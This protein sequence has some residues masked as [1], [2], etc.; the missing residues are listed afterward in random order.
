MVYVAAGPREAF[1]INDTGTVWRI[2]QSSIDELVSPECFYDVAGCEDFAIAVNIR[3]ECYG[4][5]RIVARTE[6]T[7][8]PDLVGR[9]VLHV[10]A[11]SRR[12]FVL[13]A[14]G[15]VLV[16]GSGQNGELGTETNEPYPV[17]R[18]LEL[19]N[20]VDIGLGESHT[21][22]VT[23]D[24]S[25]FG[26]GLGLDGRLFGKKGSDVFV[27][28][29]ESI[30]K[31]VNVRCGRMSTF[32]VV[33]RP[34]LRHLGILHFLNLSRCV[35]PSVFALRDDMIVRLMNLDLM[36]GDLVSF[37]GNEAIVVG[38]DHK[39]VRIQTITG[40]IV[41][42]ERS[43]LKFIDRKGSEMC[44]HKGVCYDG[45]DV[46]ERWFGLRVGDVVMKEG[47]CFE[48]LGFHKGK[49]WL[50]NCVDEEVIAYNGS[51]SDFWK[52]YSLE[53]T[54][55]NVVSR[56]IGG[57]VY[58]IKPME[59]VAVVGFGSAH[60]VQIIGEFAAF[61]IGHPLFKPNH[62][63]L[64]PKQQCLIV[65]RCGRFSQYDRVE[66]EGQA[67]MLLEVCNDCGLVILDDG[68]RIAA[69]PVL[70]PLESLIVTTPFRLIPM[71]ASER[72]IPSDVF[73]GER[74]FVTVVGSKV[75]GGVV[76]MSARDCNGE[77][78]DLELDSYALVRRFYRI[79]C[80]PLRLSVNPLLELSV[81]VGDMVGFGFLPFDE[82]EID[83]SSWIVCGVS[84]S[85]GYVVVVNTDG[86]LACFPSYGDALRT[87]KLVASPCPES[88]FLKTLFAKCL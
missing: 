57:V 17:F 73:F 15:S 47:V 49:F 12:A 13:L 56:E 21:M 75:E 66:Y 36:M 14:D 45:G 29:P 71:S 16:W 81:Q 25:M 18:E 82:V 8:I 80:E 23:E 1:A 34:R 30:G 54:S 79:D 2:T 37:D 51:V 68:M 64:Y 43:D 35:V 38:I 7:P 26:A 74:G 70:V 69:P 61:Y 86:Q 22:F 24:G 5:G 33:N 52:V 63:E 6:W 67:G 46:L 32:A 83:R 3:H 87:A 41:S 48:A 72:C 62:V 39:N 50:K 58:P 42:T 4:Y 53:K 28:C 40:K 10:F 44:M 60:Y 88:E 19:R 59:E 78:F 20:V 65:R 9:S 31:V 27:K 76:S 77:E 55:R 84:L 85:D 11:H